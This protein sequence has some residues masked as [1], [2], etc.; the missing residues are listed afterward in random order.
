MD[1]GLIDIFPTNDVLGIQTIMMH[2]DIL[3]TIIDDTWDGTVYQPDVIGEIFLACRVEGEVIGVYRL[4][5]ITGVTLQIHAHIL[6]EYRKK[7]SKAS[8]MAAL[9]WILDNIRRCEKVDCCVP[10]VYPNVRQ[11]VVAC[12]FTE[13]GK[14]RKAFKLNNQLHDMYWYGITAAEMEQ[15]T[16]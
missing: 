16:K 15:V 3:P 2:E 14:S 9:R 13:E 8:G 10:E 11:F 6:K 1:F 4:H 7:W 12:G 5:W